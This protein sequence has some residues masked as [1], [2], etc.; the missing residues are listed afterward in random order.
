MH[1]QQPEFVPHA[2]LVFLIKQRL[3]G[4]KAR[5]ERFL[6]DQRQQRL[7]QATQIPE[8]D[9]GLLIEG[10]AAVVIGVVADKPRIVVI[11]KPIGAIIHRQTKNRHIVGVHHPMGPTDRLP[12]RDQPRGA[13]NDFVEKPRVFFIDIAEMGKV[14]VDHIIG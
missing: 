6:L 14:S 11:H 12:L 4:P 1:I 13:L 5:F 9:V 8:S 10:I 2:L 7:S 3:V